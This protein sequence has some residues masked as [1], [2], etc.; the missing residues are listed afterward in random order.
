MK[1]NLSKEK[2]YYH[3]IKIEKGKEVFCE[4][5]VLKFKN[6]TMNPFDEKNQNKVKK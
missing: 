3:R 4:T 1:M 6:K 2:Y 5:K